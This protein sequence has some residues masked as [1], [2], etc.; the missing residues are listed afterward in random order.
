MK[1]LKT[2]ESF[3]QSL[4]EN[5]DLSPEMKKEFIDYVCEFYCKGKV[6]SDI[7]RNQLTRKMVNDLFNGWYNKYIKKHEFAGDSVDR[8]N[9]R[10]HMLL[11]YDLYI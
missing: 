4:N 3:S 1:N 8:E 5:S 7:F 9:F 10:D 6:H 11:I 2:F